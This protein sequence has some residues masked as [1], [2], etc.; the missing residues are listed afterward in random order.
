MC[1]IEKE[2]F[3]LQP[4]V[5]IEVHQAVEDVSQA[6]ILIQTLQASFDYA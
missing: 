2:R 6:Q 5:V 3:L 1:L 4:T